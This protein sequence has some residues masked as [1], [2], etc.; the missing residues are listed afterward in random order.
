MAVYAGSLVAVP[1]ALE[2][3]TGMA[4]LGANTPPH[5]LN[6]IAPTQTLSTEPITLF[7]IAGDPDPGAKLTYVF[8]VLAGGG[9]FSS[10]TTTNQT[11][12]NAVSTVYTP[13]VGFSG[14]AVIQVAVTD[15]LA[16]TATTVPIAISP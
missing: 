9:S 14:F 1:I 4:V 2:P 12:G 15:G 10:T 3:V 13:M 11:P 5:F 8:S 6:L 7:A 16:T